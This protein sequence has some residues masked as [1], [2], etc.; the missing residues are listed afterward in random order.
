MNLSPQQRSAGIPVRYAKAEWRTRIE[1]HEGWDFATF[2]DHCINLGVI[3][4][5]ARNAAHAAAICEWEPGDP[6]LYIAGP[7]GTGKTLLC[8]ALANRLCGTGEPVWRRWAE[9]D[10]EKLRELYGPDMAMGLFTGDGGHYYRPQGVRVAMLNER[11]LHRRVALG[12]AK[13]KAPLAQVAAADLVILDDLGTAVGVTEKAKD[14]I[15]DNIERLVCAR[16]DRGQPMIITSNVPLS[17]VRGRYGARTSRRLKE[18]CTV[19]RLTGET[20]SEA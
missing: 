19:H 13:D 6:W 17:E 1:Q 5:T 11:E 15:V 2:R 16:Y 12:W 9:C 20:W 18:M 7:V 8:A 4:V 3:G 10:P 14:I